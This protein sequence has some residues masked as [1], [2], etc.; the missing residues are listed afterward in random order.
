MTH[1]QLL[2][3]DALQELVNIGGGNAATSVSS[4]IEKPVQMS[5]P[6]VAEMDYEEVFETVKS[7]ADNV[8]AV[9][10]KLTGEG[11]GTF[12][13]VMSEESAK[14]WTDLLFQ[15]KQPQSEELMDSALKELVNILVHSFL[16][17]VI[18]VLGVNLLAS[19][20]IL[21]EDMFGSIL[22]SLYMDQQQYDNQVIILK[23]AFFCEGEHIEGS[24]YFVPGPGILETLLELMGV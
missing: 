12:L 15:G 3:L 6:T 1:S 17:A 22:S 11:Q 9:L 2:R 21:I 16:N 8:K 24:L 20:P 4:L 18:Q 23:T 5:I 10:M 14:D 7:E 19:V 13:F